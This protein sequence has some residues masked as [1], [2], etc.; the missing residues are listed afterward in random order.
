MPRPHD[1]RDH[2]DHT[3]E[4]DRLELISRPTGPGGLDVVVDHREHEPRPEPQ[5]PRRHG[6]T[7]ALLLPVRL[8]TRFGGSEQA[9][10]L[11]VRVYPDQIHVDTHEPEFTESEVKATREYW[12]ALWRAGPGDS[13]GARDA[14]RVLANRFGATRAAY[15]AQAPELE[16]TNP[17]ARPAA[18]TPEGGT[19]A[20]A[21]TFSSVP[22]SELREASWTRAPRA[23]CL[24]HRWTVLLYRD[25]S[26]VGRATGGT[27]RDPL[28]LGP[29]PAAPDTVGPDGLALDDHARWLIDFDEAVGAGMALRIPITPADLAAGFD[30]VLVYGLCGHHHHD[31]DADDGHEHGP[32]GETAALQELLLAHRFTDGLALVPQG[33]PTNNTAEAPAAY[34]SAD[35]GFERSYAVEQRDALIQRDGAVLRGALGLGPEPLDHLQHADRD[36]QGNSRAMSLAVWPATLGYFLLTL[37]SDEV[38]AA[39][40]AARSYFLERVRPRGPLP[41][42]RV[43]EVPYGIVPATSLALFDAGKERSVPGRPCRARSPAARSPRCPTASP[44]SVSARGPRGG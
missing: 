40:P 23:S 39:E 24:A 32:E 41:A 6:A 7:P 21:P 22:S 43:G 27:I 11:W 8:E 3:E 33:S 9:P 12:D 25:G 17:G 30:R 42:F 20:A 34:A 4:P 16:P 19:L 10:E 14:W 44:G 36:D 35:P 28:A 1:H 38:A 26:V 29:D 37:T 15:L 2:P 13:A 5:P 18:P 31:D